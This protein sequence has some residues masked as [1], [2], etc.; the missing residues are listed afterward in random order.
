MCEHVDGTHGKEMQLLG[1]EI[2]NSSQNTHLHLVL[3]LSS[4]WGQPIQRRYGKAIAMGARIQALQGTATST[5]RNSIFGRNT[6]DASV[7]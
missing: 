4:F 5:N 6:D 1:F 2:G 3:A 7:T